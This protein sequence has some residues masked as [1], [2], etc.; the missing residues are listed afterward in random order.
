MGFPG[1]KGGGK[2]DGDVY[3][4]GKGE[5]GDKK[6]DR[7]GDQDG[8]GKGEK[9]DRR[10]EKGADKG[11]RK[12]DRKGGEKGGEKGDNKGDRKGDKDGKGK[13][14]KDGKGKGEKGKGKGKQEKLVSKGLRGKII[15]FIGGK[16]S[17]FIQRTDGDRDVYFDMA[18]ILD[19]ETVEQFDPVEFDVVEGQDQ[20]LY[21]ARVKKLPK[22]TNLEEGSLKS[23]TPAQASKVGSLTGGLSL[24]PAKLGGGKLSGGGLLSGGLSL[25]PGGA[26]SPNGGI[27]PPPKPKEEP[28]PSNIDE[29]SMADGPRDDGICWG[30]IVSTRGSFGFLKQLGSGGDGCDIFFRAAD[31]IGMNSNDPGCEG[32]EIILSH[33][34]NSNGFRKFFLNVEDEISYVMSKDHLGKPCASDVCKERKGAWRTGRRGG[35]SKPAQR[36]ETIK[37]QMKRLVAMDTDQVL[38]N[39]SL[40]KEVLENPDFEPPHLYKVVT[41]L[42]SKELA[43][44]T[45][46]DRLYRVFLESP[47]MQALLRTTIIKQGAGKHQGEFL[48]EC[49]RLLFEIVMRSPTPQELRGQMPLAELVDAWENSV[50]GGSSVGRKGLSEDVVNMLTCLQKNFPEEVN[51]GRVLGAKAP[52]LNRSAAEDYT[53]LLEADDYRDMPILPT[54]AEMIGQCAF[55]VQENMRTYEKCEDYI[56][57]HFMLLREDYIEPL[58]AGIK[59]FMQGKHSPKDLHVYTGVKVIGV[60]S[61]WEGLVYRI[62]LPK[63]QIRKINW[64]K[65][66]QLMYGSLLCLSDDSF[67]SL[68]WATVWRRDETLIATQAQLD[69][70]IPFEP[71]CDALSPGKT[72][73]CI[74]NVT[75]YFEA[76]RHV[77]IA[78]QNMRP[79]DVPFQNTLLHPQPDPCPPTF[80]KADSDMWHLKNIFQSVEKA[81]SL[82]AAPKSFKILQEW[83]ASLR[84]SLDLDYSQLDA[85]QHALT[86]QMALIQGPPGTGKTFVGLKMVQAILENT[87]EIRHSPILVVCYTNHALDQFLEGIFKF[88]EK[89]ARIGS[90]SKSELMKTRNLKELMNEIQPSREYFQARKALMDR[91]DLLRA[92]LTKTLAD[93]DRHT[94]SAANAKEVLGETKFEQFYE[95]YLEFMAGDTA[96]LPEDALEVDDELWTQITKDW[97]QTKSDLAKLAPV[98]RKEV[99]GLPTLEKFGLDADEDSDEEDGANAKNGD[100]EEQEADFQNHDRKLD[101]E[102]VDERLK[103]RQDYF[104][105]L[106]NAW[107]PWM[108]EHT[109]RLS[110][111]LRSLDWREENLWRLPLGLRREAYR[112]WLL[113]AHHAARELLPELA[114][115]LERNADHR[116]ALERDR[117]LAV[118]REMEV[119]GMT[120]TAVS[121]YQQLLK[122]LRPE[123][124]VVEEAAEVL[125]AHILTA[126]HARTQHVVLIGDHQQLRPSTAVYRLSKNFHLDVSLFERLIHNGA[127]HVTLQ[128]QRRMHPSVS[129]LIK[130]LYPLLRDHESTSEYPEVMGVNARCYFMRHHHFEDDDDAGH[131]KQNTFEANF[132][133]A[134]CAHLVKSGYDESKITVL[135]PYLGQVRLLKNKLK[136]DPTTGGVAVQAVDNFQGEEN[137]IIVVSLVRSN[138]KNQMG[139][140]A[141]DNRINVALTRA[142]HGMF[143]IG[144]GDMLTKHTLWSSIMAELAT[145]NCIGDTLPLLDVDAEGVYEVRSADEIGVLLGSKIHETGGEG[146]I[147]LDEYKRAKE[148]KKKKGKGK[149]KG[150]AQGGDSGRGDVADRWADLDKD[151]DRKGGGKGKGKR[152]NQDTNWSQDRQV[153]DDD[154][155]QVVSAASYFQARNASSGNGDAS[156]VE[157]RPP[158]TRMEADGFECEL[159]QGKSSA[160]ED[161]EAAKKGG[162]KQQKKQKQV[163]LK[164][165][166]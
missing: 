13:G 24:G 163:F 99:G 100:D 159:V 153:Y 14:D 146:M 116:A 64:E 72:F 92:E 107:L 61:T 81:D 152:N 113:E 41:K 138:R 49:L 145:D 7:K 60:L 48:E 86:N 87:R 150:S 162:K 106:N 21:A 85:I 57:T 157:H 84:E 40:F 42:A 34:R 44:D 27:L 2:T 53:E 68:I 30:R 143:I 141:V 131:S 5:K 47:A 32:I 67:E 104:Q 121:K 120:T 89:M 126:L 55:E 46:S 43:E 139:F 123:V 125:E 93:V 110:P 96:H 62:E 88:N 70:R 78:L 16:P 94:I 58:R 155:E 17:G 69:I 117:K 75:I 97:L 25:R 39:A 4:G 156:V 118:L 77:L 19:G 20:K 133:S 154:Q 73:C 15:Q 71:F 103:S 134:L 105:E 76:Y 119:V 122:E 66:K 160:K 144:N 38:Q 90:R 83:P 149:G 164:L 56:Q 35:A 11:D 82:V 95:G 74:E 108:E 8:K 115:L 29:P 37:D 136:R 127:A 6:G 45:R 3:P 59:L 22:G 109:E 50:R 147:T 12:G 112:Q 137:D 91:R 10:D 129:R 142:R 165:S 102:P 158:P 161:D 52:K 151:G 80:L 28:K 140:V 128:Q 26:L 79:S 1:E 111:E 23:T 51:L 65:S 18:D 166:G 114:R 101:V 36:T 148:A 98:M 63:S 54:S 135:S 33:A 130:P 31:V 9:G 124:V 132:I